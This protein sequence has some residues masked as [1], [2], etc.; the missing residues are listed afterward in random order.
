[1]STIR[2]KTAVSLS[3]IF[4][5]TGPARSVQSAKICSKNRKKNKGYRNGILFSYMIQVLNNKRLHCSLCLI[6]SCF[7]PA[8]S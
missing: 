3:K 1:M 8:S 2:K 5:K 6:F 4:R 7:S